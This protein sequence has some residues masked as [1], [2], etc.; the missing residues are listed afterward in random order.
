DLRSRVF[1]QVG[2]FSP[3]ELAEFGTPS[4]ITRSTNDV[5]QVRM[6]V[7][8]SLNMLVQAPTTGIGGVI[9]ALR[10]APGM[11]WLIAVV[12]P[13]LLVAVGIVSHRAARLFKQMQGEI[14]AIN[15]VLR[16]QITG[17]RVLRAFV[18]A[19]RERSRYAVVNGE[20]TD[21][22]RRVGLLMI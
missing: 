17:I 9:L 20:L 6:L 18:R 8:S 16:E 5:Q 3:R 22:N 2:S 19:G 10:V 15:S 14:D 12:G 7:F 13:G 11:A 1:G 21:L 4:L